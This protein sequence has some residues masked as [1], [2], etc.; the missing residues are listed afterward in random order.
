LPLVPL[1]HAVLAVKAF[2]REDPR[3]RAPRRTAAA[4]TA[5][6]RRAAFDSGN[7]APR[8]LKRRQTVRQHRPAPGHSH[9][10]R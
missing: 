9:Y 1:C 10:Q 7:P 8:P 2:A 6:L 3:S 5:A 4:L